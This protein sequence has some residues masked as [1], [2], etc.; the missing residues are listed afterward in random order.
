[1][2]PASTLMGVVNVTPD[3][4]SDGGRFLDPAA[5]IDHALRLAQDGAGILDIGGESTRPGAEPVSA[6]EELR[7]VIP[8]V[9]GLAGRTEAVVSIDTSKAA[10]AREALAAGAS[11]VNDVTGLTG[12]PDMLGV[13]VD[14][15]CDACVM[16]MRGTP[17][18]MQEAPR[19]DDV[20]ADVKGYLAERRDALESAGVPRERIVIDPGIGF[21]KTFE[22]NLELLRRVG[23][24]RELG[25]R[26]LVGHSRKR[27]LG[28]ILGDPG[29][30]RTAATVGVAVWLASQGVDILRVHDVRETADALKAYRAAAGRATNG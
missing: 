25:C 13:V 15:G 22:H 16:H 10:V 12:D 21:G 19:Y 5:A 29:A 7:R 23:G 3:S 30:D 6:D 18:T 1:M 14:A 20:V 2:S 9:E 8:V 28:E 24:F 27:F 17:R 4:F 11:L 26:V